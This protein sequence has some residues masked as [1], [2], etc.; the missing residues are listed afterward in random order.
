MRHYNSQLWLAGPMANLIWFCKLLEFFCISIESDQIPRFL[1]LFFNPSLSYFFS[2][3]RLT[4][5]SRALQL[6]SLLEAKD[7][8]GVDGAMR[9]ITGNWSLAKKT[10]ATEY[11]VVL[12]WEWFSPCIYQLGFVIML[13][14]F[15]Q[16]ALFQFASGNSIL[17]RLRIRQLYWWSTNS[18]DRPHFTLTTTL[19][20]RKYFCKCIML[21]IHMNS[22]SY[23]I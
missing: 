18:K 9:V 22:F 1:L 15:A 3:C 23:W 2:R 14:Y 7:G 13:I 19:H 8:N 17:I 4:L 10:F 12:S 16:L 11:C 20:C 5:K 6:T 21:D